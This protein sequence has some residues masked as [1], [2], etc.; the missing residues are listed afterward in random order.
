MKVQVSMEIGGVEKKNFHQELEIFPPVNSSCITKS[1]FT[2]LLIQSGIKLSISE[3]SIIS[4]YN[5]ERHAYCTLK[6]SDPVPILDSLKI[7][8]RGQEF[9]TIE[10]LKKNL[11]DLENRI[12]T[13]TK[14]LDQTSNKNEPKSGPKPSFTNKFEQ[15]YSEL[16][17]AMLGSAPLVHNDS[18]I[19]YCSLDFEV[20][21]RKLLEKLMLEGIKADV[22]FEVATL[23]N[24]AEILESKPKIIYLSCQGY[25]RTSPTNEFVLAFEQSIEDPQEMSKI[26]CLE[27]VDAEKLKIV[28]DNAPQY[29]QV[30]IIKGAYSQEMAKVLIKAGFPCIIAVHQFPDH[31][32]MTETQTAHNFIAE[33]CINLLSG[34]SINESFKLLSEIYND[35]EHSCCCAHEHLDNCPWLEKLNLSLIYENH[36][37]HMLKCSCGLPMQEH[38]N[39]CQTADNFFLDLYPNSLY[40]SFHGDTLLVCCCK[41]NYGNVGLRHEGFKYVKFC[42]DESILDTILFDSHEKIELNVISDLPASW[43]PPYSVSFTDA[44]RKEIHELLGLLNNNRSV[45]LYGESGMGKTMMLKRAGYYAYERKLFSDGVVYFD[46]TKRDIVFLYRTISKTLNLPV[47]DHY[48]ELF[49]VLNEKDVLLIMD[50]IDELISEKK[51]NFYETYENM[52]KSTTKPKFII[53]CVEKIDLKNCKFFKLSG[54]SSEQKGKFI[55]RRIENI[56]NTENFDKISNKPSDLIKYTE[57]QKNR[58]GSFKGQT[59]PELHR[60]STFKIKVP[61]SFHFFH[62]LKNLQFGAFRFS[63]QQIWPQVQETFKDNSQKFDEMLKNLNL[64]PE[65]LD[66]LLIREAGDE[67]FKLKY[68]FLNLLQI[69][70]QTPA[71]SEIYLKLSLKS[72]AVVARSILSASLKDNFRIGYEYRNNLMFFNAALD[73]SIWNRFKQSGQVADKIFDPSIT[74]EKI[75]YNFW[76]Y[77]KNSELTKIYN[78]GVIQ[79]DE[80]K[81][82]LSEIMLCTSS[83]FLL[84]GNIRDLDEY[85]ERCKVCCKAFKLDM[86]LNV[87]NF[88]HAVVYA[89]KKL[90]SECL[91]LVDGCEKCFIDTED[92]QGVAECYLLRALVAENFD[93]KIGKI[94]KSIELFKNHQCPPGYARGLLALVELKNSIEQ[95]DEEFKSA[96]LE[97]SEIFNQNGMKIWKNKSNLYL[98]NYF[99][100]QEKLSISREILESSLKSVKGYKDSK[101]EREITKKLQE[102]N[103]HIVKNNKNSICLLKAFPLVDKTENDVISKSNLIWRYSS[104]FRIDLMNSLQK[105]NKKIYVRMDILSMEKLEMCLKEK[106]AILHIA[107]DM[108]GQDCLYFEKEEG[109][110]H[111]ISFEDFKKAIQASPSDNKIKLLVFSMPSSLQLATKSYEELKIKHVICFDFPDCPKNYIR[112]LINL[113]FE[114]SIHYFIVNFYK[115]LAKQQSVKSAFQKAKE[116]MKQFMENELKN[117]IYLDLDNKQGVMEWWET[118]KNNDPILIDAENENHLDPVFQFD[119]DSEGSIIELSPVRGPCNVRCTGLPFN[120]FV[121]RQ[122]E[123]HNLMKALNQTK[124]INIF[125]S[126]GIGK[127]EFVKQVAYYLFVRNKYPDGIF[128]LQLR[129]QHSLEDV[130]RVFKNEGLIGLSTDIDPKTF[131]LDKK[132]LLILENCETMLQKAPHTLNSL[133]QKFV[134]E[135]N[136]SVIITSLNHLQKIDV[137]DIRRIALRNMTRMENYALLCLFMPKF[138]TR[139]LDE[140]QDRLLYNEIVEKLL[141]EFQGVPGKI[142]K[143]KKLLDMERLTSIR[144]M[145]KNNLDDFDDDDDNDSLPNLGFKRSSS[146]MNKE[147]NRTPLPRLSGGRSSCEHLIKT[148]TAEI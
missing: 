2:S 104:S 91:Q 93:E 114:K 24:L 64:A 50:N 123:M 144:E 56:R 27:E 59:A 101:V 142:Q 99:F 94:K 148:H 95:F 4:Y 141:K 70:V 61:G 139:Q 8:I 38:K 72:L 113:V 145:L 132:I 30:V 79:S 130:Y 19:E 137:K 31:P 106:P 77:I 69:Q 76:C 6:S 120:T 57:N 40:S 63:I 98:S 5:E 102:I 108:Q 117:F 88:L 103:E 107:S 125:G 121:G 115:N 73:H 75:E 128:L 48:T 11:Q 7:L 135:C 74:F 127:T 85:I 92:G 29:F 105:V 1:E 15:S 109:F 17:I 9:F 16:D 35:G 100:N 36:K 25:Y 112:V 39:T 37:F 96:C 26:G 22:R 20:E 97:C 138:V 133:L 129:D 52:I 43:K 136:I 116:K 47:F 65:N 53:G 87:I 86:T 58:P 41:N 45:N 13:L 143:Y 67:F 78:K 18:P 119:P 146:T 44:R 33:F 54:L 28:L 80:V 111:K 46:F 82:Y 12:K 140:E 49:S 10:I 32:T 118:N 55:R 60:L 66:Y 126:E 14:K 110:A 147:F 23:N 34:K 3:S 62:I 21:R 134:N 90:I 131:L 81:E 71:A 89:N 84:F 51:K 83:I 68:E 42:S 122:G 124:C